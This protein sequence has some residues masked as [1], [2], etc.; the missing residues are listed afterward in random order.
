[1]GGNCMIS[2][3][4]LR[5]YARLRKLPLG[6]AELEYFQNVVLFIL[7]E[8]FGKELVF[9]GGTALSRAYGLGRFSEDLD[10]TVSG[11]VDVKEVLE[12]GLKRFF[13]EAEW[14]EEN[15]GQSVSYTL[16]IKGPLYMGLRQSMCRVMLDL[17]LREKVLREPKRVTI[18]RFLFEVPAFEVVVMD[19]EEI[20]VEKVRALMT[21]MKARDVYDLWYLLGLGTSV[22]VKMVQQ[23][24]DL[25][26]KKFEV[27]LFMKEVLG[28]K[29]G[30]EQE[31][32]PLVQG[33]LPGFLEVV[34]VIRERIK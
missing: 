30:W 8:Q 25:Y 24:L 6:Q 20:L 15:S 10:F 1:M 23:K 18:G 4:E 16:R 2:T 26:G 3:E 22:D 34:K 13:V 7:Y 31:L 28:H 21:R 5:E 17:S 19:A 32:K 29:L 12:K 33:R 9:K 11:R 14:E 27:R